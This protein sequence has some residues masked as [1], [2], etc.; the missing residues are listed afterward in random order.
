MGRCNIICSNPCR[1]FQVNPITINHPGRYSQDK[2]TPANAHREWFPIF[3]VG[4]PYFLGLNMEMPAGQDRR[5][6]VIDS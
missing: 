2:T 3:P 5:D 6:M 4:D 1:K